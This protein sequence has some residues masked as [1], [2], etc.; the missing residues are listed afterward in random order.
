[1][2]WYKTVYIVL[3]F[4]SVGVE[5]TVVC[6]QTA[7]H[8]RGGEFAGDRVL[9][10]RRRRAVSE[11]SGLLLQHERGVRQGGKD[12]CQV[13]RTRSDRRDCHHS[14]YVCVTTIFSVFGFVFDIMLR[15][16]IGTGNLI[17]SENL[18]S[19]IPNRPNYARSTRIS[20][21]VS[22]CSYAS[23]YYL[24]TPP[25]ASFGKP[26]SRMSY[27][28]RLGFRK[29]LCSQVTYLPTGRHRARYAAAWRVPFCSFDAVT[30][31]NGETGWLSRRRFPLAV[32]NQ[33]W[34]WKR[35]MFFTDFRPCELLNVLI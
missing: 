7:S 9:Q 18:D 35:L 31:W 26:A 11:R 19:I 15:I 14:Y 3:R 6:G 33:Y 24:K 1:M 20:G 30:R 28:P 25:H 12:R 27:S 29:Y 10:T 13:K 8:V 22:A 5:Q 2:F 16:F 34:K 4:S 32:G 21:C 23:I 17:Y